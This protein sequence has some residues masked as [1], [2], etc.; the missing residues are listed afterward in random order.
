MIGWLRTRVRNQP[1]IALYFEFDTVLK[2]YNLE[3]RADKDRLH[4][5]NTYAGCHRKNIHLVFKPISAYAP[6]TKH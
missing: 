4:K 5:K 6:L 2:F 3:T 1:I